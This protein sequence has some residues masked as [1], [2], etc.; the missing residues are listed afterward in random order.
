MLLFLF[1]HQANII[2]SIRKVNW[3]LAANFLINIQRLI[4]EIQGFAVFALSL[5]YWPYIMDGDRILNGLRSFYILFYFQG[6]TVV[7]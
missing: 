2:Q 5:V 7:V 6:F 3:L 1:K 4:I